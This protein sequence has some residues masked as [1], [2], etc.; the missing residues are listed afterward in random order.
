MNDSK[1]PV[2]SEDLSG[3]VLSHQ[4]PSPSSEDGHG[5]N[6]G[7]SGDMKKPVVGSVVAQH[8]QHPWV[9]EQILC[10]QQQLQ[11]AQLTQQI[12]SRCTRGP[13]MPSTLAAGDDLGQPHVPAGF[14]GCNFVQL[15]SW[16]PRSVSGCL[17]TSQTTSCQH[18]FCR[19]LSV[20]KADALCSEAGWNQGAPKHHVSSPT[21]VLSQTPGSV[22]FQSPFSTVVLDP[23]KKGKR[24]PL[25]ISAADVTPGDEAVLHKHR[26]GAVS[27]PCLSEPSQPVS[28]WK[29]LARWWDPQ[30]CLQEDPSVS[31]PAMPS[32]MAAHGVGS[33]SRPLALFRVMSG[34]TLE[35]SL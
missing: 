24:K 23:S 7:S 19:Q 25:N 32:N 20:P 2:S 31:S 12:A 13:L 14:Y 4:P 34:L 11:Q 10:L 22:L 5:E 1:G 18:P 9:L 28:K 30:H 21:S 3:A 8:Q 16:K 27:L 17:E 26:C 29:F 6:G 15:E 35:T 33:T